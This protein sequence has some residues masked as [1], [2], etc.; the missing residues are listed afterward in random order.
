NKLGITTDNVKTGHLSDLYSMTGPLNDYEKLYIQK[1]TDQ[2]YKAFISKAAE[3]R[4]MDI[5]EME[6]FASGRIWT[7]DEA[8]ENGLI[9]ILGDLDD[10]IAIAAEKA[11]VAEDY[12]IRVYPIQKDPIEE[13]LQALSGDY[14]TNVLS[15]KL[16]V[17]YPYVQSLETLK[18]LQGIQARSLVKVGF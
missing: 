14:E 3:D 4:S 8:L 18:E 1:G 9:D 15:K 5:D 12:R 2:A 16:G 17:F 6:P 11:G 13:L 10:A 7:G